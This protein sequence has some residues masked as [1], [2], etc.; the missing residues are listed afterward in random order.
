[1]KKRQK[2]KIQ[3]TGMSRSSAD[4]E[5]HQSDPLDDKSNCQTSADIDSESSIHCMEDTDDRSE[6]N[7]EHQEDEKEVNIIK[8]VVVES[9][10]TR[11]VTVHSAGCRDNDLVDIYD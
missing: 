8:T 11:L 2:N 6:N 7:D 5:P 3:E 4:P 1:M 10:T 9:R